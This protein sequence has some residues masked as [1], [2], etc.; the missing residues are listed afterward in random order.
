[1]ITIFK[2][3]SD[4][5]RLQIMNYV[6]DKPSTTQA[7]A[8]IL[9]MSNSSISRHLQILKDANLLTTTKAKN[10]FKK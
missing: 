2:A 10:F 7:L 1:M 9:L 8:Q 6:I 5:V 4:P 3:L